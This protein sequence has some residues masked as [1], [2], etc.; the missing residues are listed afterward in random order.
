MAGERQVSRVLIADPSD[1]VLLLRFRLRDGREV[2]IPPGGGVEPGETPEEAARR[3]LLEETAVAVPGGLQV[4]WLNRMHYFGRD[5]METYFFAR[6]P[7]RPA[8][9]L[10][11][12]PDAPAELLDHRWWT[13]EQLADAPGDALVTPS[14]IAERLPAVLGGRSAEAPVML[15]R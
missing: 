10:E 12:A 2:W 14:E 15:G 13:A 6:L 7:H 3:E 5:V 8:V 4:V 9:V 1:H 11:H